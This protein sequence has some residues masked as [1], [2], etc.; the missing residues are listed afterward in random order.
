MK[1]EVYSEVLYLPLRA[2]FQ[3]LYVICEPKFYASILFT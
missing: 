1:R 3:G 2:T